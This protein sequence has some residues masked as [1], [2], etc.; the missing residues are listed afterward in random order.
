M[1]ALIKQ[2]AG[3]GDIF[4]CQ[5]IAKKIQD[6]GYEIIWPVIPEF[7]WIEDY[8]EGICFCDLDNISK[9]GYDIILPLQDADKFFPG[10]SVMEA[11]YKLVNLKYDNWC[12]YFNFKRN[13]YKESQ[14][15]YDVLK[16]SDSEPYTLKNYYFASPPHTQI[17]EAVKSANCN[18]MRE[19]NMSNLTSFTLLDW[20]KVIQSAEVIH[21][22]ETSLNYII[23]KLN[24]TSN[25]NM[26]SKWKPANFMHIEKIFNKPWTFHF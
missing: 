22:V 21:T 25:L 12:K 5:K 7:L 11:K 17:C 15:F 19:V 1:K 13:E 6:R 4:F 26:Y 3:I 14:L 2:P 24:T 18:G 20:C 16:L 23:E 8:I 10:I 9:L